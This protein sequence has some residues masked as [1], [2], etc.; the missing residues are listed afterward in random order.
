MARQ[1][2][3]VREREN[4]KEVIETE[5]QAQSETGIMRKRREKFIETDKQTRRERERER[6]A[7][8]GRQ[9]KKQTNTERE[10]KKEKNKGRNGG[11]VR[12]CCPEAC[13]NLNHLM[14][15]TIQIYQSAAHA[16][17]NMPV[18]FTLNIH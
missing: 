6:G 14:D 3:I 2:Y 8:T 9:T 7:Q 13:K 16:N 5:R 11:G 4:E 17:L 12:L 18:L 10:K 1:T 15:R